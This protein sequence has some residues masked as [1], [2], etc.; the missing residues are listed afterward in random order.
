MS[1]IGQAFDP[2][3]I[4]VSLRKSLVPKRNIGAHEGDLTANCLNEPSLADVGGAT[5]EGWIIKFHSDN[6]F[7]DMV[8]VKR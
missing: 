1:K 7:I 4:D 3:L 5:V 8:F 6:L 2:L